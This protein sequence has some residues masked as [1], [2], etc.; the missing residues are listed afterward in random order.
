MKEIWKPI[1]VFGKENP[2]YS[3]SNYGN[4][5][6]HIKVTSKGKYGSISEYQERYSYPLKPIKM[7][8]NSGRIRALRLAGLKFP[9]DF[10]DDEGHSYSSRKQNGVNKDVYIHQLVMNVFK[11]IDLH[12]PKAIKPYWND[13]PESVKQWIR[14]TVVIDHLDTDPTNNHVDNLEYVTPKENSRRALEYYGGSF[15][16]KYRKSD[17]DFKKSDESRNALME[18]LG[19]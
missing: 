4:A 3:V 14:D 5:V 13:L 7:R 2:W 6:S 19:M 8:N 11:P 18:I 15:D 1:V 16:P 17:S 12:P 9:L 10:F